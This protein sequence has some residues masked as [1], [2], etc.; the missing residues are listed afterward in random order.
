M[1]PV[2][3]QDARIADYVHESDNLRTE[4][5]RGIDIA[6]QLCYGKATIEKIARAQSVFEVSRI[7]KQARLDW[8]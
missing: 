8:D 5:L 6:E 2:I 1:A 4:I 7:L 3:F